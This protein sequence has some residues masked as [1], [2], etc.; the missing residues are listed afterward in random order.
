M[1]ERSGLVVVGED[2]AGPADAHGRKRRAHLE[3]RAVALDDLA[4]EGVHRAGDELQERFAR[5]GLRGF[6]FV[7]LDA[8]ARARPERDAR[9]IDHHQLHV[10]VGTGQQQVALAH[11]GIPGK[12]R[13]ARGAL[14]LDVTGDELRASR[15]LG[16]RAAGKE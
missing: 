7:A 13:A 14:H 9:R 16:P 1:V 2:V 8:H 5:A 15:D 6:E 4:G 10:A 3:A 11:L 12:R